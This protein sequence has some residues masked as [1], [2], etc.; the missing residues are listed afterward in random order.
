MSKPDQTP[1]SELLSRRVVDE[2]ERSPDDAPD[3]IA[4]SS[5]PEAF[6]AREAFTDTDGDDEPQQKPKGEKQK[7]ETQAKPKGEDDDEGDSEPEGRRLDRLPKW[8]YLRI[9]A[10]NQKAEQAQREAAELR[11]K[12]DA[13]TAQRN[14]APEGEEAD[15]ETWDQWTQKQIKAVEDRFEQRDWNR[16]TTFSYRL[17]LKE[18]GEEATTEAAQWAK[19]QMQANRAF[20]AAMYQSDDPYE[21]AITEFRKAQFELEAQKFGYDV[22]KM[23]AARAAKQPAQGQQ[24]QPAAGVTKGEASPTQTDPR[25]PSDFASTGSGAGR[26]TGDNTGPTPLSDL[27]QLNTRRR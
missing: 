24:P 15:E 16:R 1:M 22:E 14:A 18:H 6:E 26:A 20:A 13:L 10:N 8:A 17:A 21:F 19:D 11:Q 2:R 27:L 23:L 12:L 3:S 9:Q 4:E 5:E 25:M 7:P